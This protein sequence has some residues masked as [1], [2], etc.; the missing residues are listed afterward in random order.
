MFKT[1]VAGVRRWQVFLY[2]FVSWKGA[3]T[4]LYR[5]VFEMRIRAN[6]MI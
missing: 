2:L 1:Y 4:W 5:A 3:R 6:I